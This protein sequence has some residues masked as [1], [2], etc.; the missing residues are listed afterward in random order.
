MTSG[1][2]FFDLDKTII[3]TSSAHTLGRELLNNGLLSRG[4]ALHLAF[5]QLSYLFSTHSAEQMESAK[6]RLSTII[7]GLE[8]SEVHRVAEETM[9]SVL[10]PRIYAEARQL[11]KEHQDR[12]E[13]VII[14]SASIPDLVSVIASELGV[15]DV[16]GSKLEVKDG[17]YTGN[18]PFYCTGPHKAM[19]I[20][21]LALERGYD[22]SRS[23]AY[24]DALADLPMLELVSHPVAVNPDRGL[25]RVASERDWEILSFRNPVPLITP[26]SSRDVGITTGIALSLASLAAGVW[27]YQRSRNIPS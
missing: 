1:A 22:L 24:S 15:V 19:A 27:W 11:I 14:V 10:T 3:A 7:S 25:R 17:C 12:G 16:I 4:S 5:A 21:N 23:Y 9:H 20:T 6:E 18:V 13:D 26:P 8:V 2:A